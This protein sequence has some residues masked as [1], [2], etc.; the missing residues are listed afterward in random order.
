[1][2]HNLQGGLSWDLPN[3]K[4]RSIIDSLLDNWGVDGRVIVRT[5]FPITLTGSSH[6]N[7][8]TGSLY[9]GGLNIVPNQPFYLSGRQ[10]PG[11]KVVNKAAFIPPTSTTIVGNAPRNFIRGFGANQINFAA[12]RDFRLH[13]VAVLQ[14]R[15]EAFNVL[16]HPN[17]GY[18]DPTYTDA[19]FGQATKMLNSSLGTVAAQYQQGGAR[20]MQ[21]ALRL[22]F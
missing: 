10:Y 1:M 7:A 21:L 9:Y 20:S 11:G 16:N 15:A 22:R 13:D 19:Q 4:N 12:R 8:A 17:F 2:R 18:V 5:S 6:F 14:F 3:S